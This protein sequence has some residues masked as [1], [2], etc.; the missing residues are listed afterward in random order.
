MVLI[1]I[2]LLPNADRTSFVELFANIISSLLKCLFMFF[3]CFGERVG[4]L[5]FSLES[6]LHTLDTVV[7]VCSYHRLVDLTEIS[8]L[9]VLEAGSQILGCQHG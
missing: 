7:L 1:S 3:A 4:C 2:T 9:I 6:S 5:L 8:F